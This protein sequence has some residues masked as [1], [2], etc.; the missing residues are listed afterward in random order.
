MPCTVVVCGFFGD[1]GKGKV[2]SYLAIADDVDV[3]VRAG[4]GTNA[5][6]TVVYGGRKYLMHGV[7]SSWTNPRARLLLSPGMAIH[8]KVVLAEIEGLKLHDRV[9]IDPQCA[10]VTDE[11]VARDRSGHLK[12][13]IRTMGAG[14][15]PCNADRALRIAKVARDVPELEPYLTDV[16]LEV[17]RALDEG[18]KVLVEGSQG[19]LLSLYHGF[20]PY[21][22]SKDVTASGACADAGIGP[23]R[24]TDVV[25]VL[26]AFVTRIG[27]G[28]LPG[29]MPPEEAAKRGLI[30]I[31]D[32]GMGW[33]EDLAGMK[34]RAA[35]FN[36]ELARRALML[37]GAT[38]IALTKIDALYPECSGVSEFEELS[39]GA[40]EFVAKIEH[41]LKVPVA[42]IGTGPGTHEIVDRRA[43]LGLL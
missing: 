2:V 38:M 33:D 37:N 30:E 13:K 9:G 6:H 11:H 24:V 40:R 31:E 25:V 23:T 27:L 29:E 34:R 43:E 10:I 20:Y 7:P 26:K 15:G 3:G 8:P 42:L 19:T 35:P 21:V 41:E 12:E 28:P 36:F 39:R 18:R 22:T 17:N 16:P 5:G 14:C 32:L 1:T 4:V